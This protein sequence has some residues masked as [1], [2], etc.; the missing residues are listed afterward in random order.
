M[1]KNIHEEWPDVPVILY[2]HSMGSF[3]ARLYA[4]VWSDTIKAAVISGTAGPSPVNGVGKK[5]AQVIAAVKGP[6]YISRV[7]VKANMGH[8]L[9][10]IENP[11]NANAWLSRDDQVCVD[12]KKDMRCGFP[13]TASAYRDMLTVL[14]KVSEQKWFDDLDKTLPVLLV[15]GG[16]D[17]VGNYG[18]GVRKVF[19]KL[20]SAG[21][22]DVTCQIWPDDRHEIHNELDKE[23]VF[24]F[25]E[26]WMN[27]RIQAASGAGEE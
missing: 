20:I 8:Y 17:P 3:F 4:Y 24:T 21:Q 13:F 6:E 23:E 2:G 15:A 7:I 22:Q 16:M 19:S 14:C 26:D 11:V 1:N 5:M 27:D 18:E 12:Y 9:D 10:K 25:I